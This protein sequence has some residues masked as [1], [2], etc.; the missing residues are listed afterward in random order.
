M[1]ISPEDQKY[2][3]KIFSVLKKGKLEEE[4]DEGGERMG[5]D[6]TN[7]NA[8]AEAVVNF[9]VDPFFMPAIRKRV[10][11]AHQIELAGHRSKKVLTLTPILILILTLT[12]SSSLSY[13]VVVA[14]TV[15]LWC[16]GDIV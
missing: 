2:F 14:N 7:R 16:L 1:L 6:W 12:T 11:L 3:I 13:V 10:D 4:M 5:E 15:Q 8:D 9:P